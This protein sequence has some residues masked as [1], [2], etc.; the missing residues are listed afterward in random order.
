MRALAW[1]TADLN[2]EQ[3]PAA[4]RI[5]HASATVRFNSVSMSAIDFPPMV[6]P[7]PIRLDRYQSHQAA[8]TKTQIDALVNRARVGG[9]IVERAG[10]MPRRRNRPALKPLRA[11]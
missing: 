10:R 1:P 6:L 9:I 8:A 4:A 11:T 2:P 5:L 3:I 7:L